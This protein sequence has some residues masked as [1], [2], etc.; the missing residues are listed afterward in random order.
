MRNGLIITAI[1]CTLLGHTNMAVAQQ[2][3]F[4]N[5]T[6]ND[7][8]ISN[9]I[10]RIFQDSKGFMWI[11]TW[12]GLSKYNGYNF[13]N[14]NTANGLSQNL[15][16][17][18][19]ENKNGQLYIALNSGDID[20]LDGNRVMGKAVACTAVV[21]R[22]ITSPTNQ[23]IA[24]T[25]REGILELS[26]GKMVKPAQSFPAQTY[27]DLIWLSDSLFI[28]SDEN[29]L[30]AF[31]RHFN[32][33]TQTLVG[34]N[35][36]HETKL[37]QD[38]K[39]RIWLGTYTGLKLMYGVPGKNR[40]TAFAP[41][42]AAFAIP[43]LQQGK[44]NAIFEDAAGTIWFGTTDGL[45][46]INTDGSNQLLTVKNGLSSNIVTCLMED[47]ENNLWVGT[48][49][50]ISK[51]VTKGGVR[52]YPIE[53]GVSSND[54]LFLL[55]PFKKDHFLVSTNKG[56]KIFNANTGQ[57]SATARDG[58]AW[59][60]VVPATAP[61]LFF[62]SGNLAAF[63]TLTSSFTSKQELPSLAVSKIAG[64]K[65]G[66][67]FLSDM[68]DLYFSSGNTLVKIL[69][70]RIS[71]LLVDQQGDLWAGTWQNGLF[72]IRYTFTRNN[73]IILAKQHL[74]PYQNTR[75]LFEDAQQNIWVGTR[76]HG[77]YRVAKNNGGTLAVAGFN[78]SDGLTS[79]FIKA[80]RQDARGNVWVAFYQGLD[81]L[82]AEGT[83][84]RVFNFSKVNNY[85]ASVIGMETDS[86]RS[87][88]LATGEGLAHIT[89]GNMEKFAPLPVYI[90][91]INTPDSTY[92]LNANNIQLGHLQ[93]QLLF[94]FSSP[95]FINERQ[96]LYS[97]RL[98]GS[99]S[100]E[101]SKQ[102]N[103][104]TVSYASLNPGHYIFEVRN[105]GWNGA[106]GKPATFTFTIRPPFWQTWWFITIAFF[107]GVLFIYQ[108]VK[109][110]EKNIKAI[111]AEKLK[112][113]QLNASQLKSKLEMEQIINY[114]SNS[115]I[116]KNT[117]DEVLW[118]V[119]RNLIGRLGF[120]DCMMYLW[121]ED[122]TRMI[123]KSGFGPKGSKEQ[124]NKQPFDVLPG[125]GVVGYVMQSKEP[126]LIPDTSLDSRYRPDEMVRLSE[127]TVPVIYNN[128]IIG[129][130]DSEHHERNFYT[131]QHLQILSTI[132][133]LMANKIKGIETEQLLQHTN[134]KMYS[135]NEQLLKARLEALRAQMNPHFIFNCL[136]SI[137]NLIQM[138]EKE[139]ATL[140]LSKFA[141]LIRSILENSASDT[142]PCWKDMETLKL[143]LE[144]EALRFDNKF[145]YRINV[146]DEILHGD[147]K[148]PP[149]IIQPFVENAIHH[150]LLNKIEGSKHLMISVSVA[151]NQISYVIADNGVGRAK[152]NAYKML[153]KPSHASMGMQITT[154]R[155][156]LFNRHKNGF[157]HIEDL[158]SSEGKPAGT[159]VS[160]Q[161]INQS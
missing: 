18:I 135:I 29:S 119:A 101:W 28:A 98:T 100:A 154:D 36:Y 155:I 121:N 10:R 23:V 34:D 70:Y 111:A 158:L 144:L 66:N 8:L 145:T 89:D 95:G 41:L 92:P 75:C 62:S 160:I 80:I 73:F 65:N 55:Y 112:V 27:A 37:Y 42:P 149:L 68:E 15:V 106:W 4:K 146:Q 138:D 45:V 24:L 114:F 51:I 48:A 152:A 7:G 88:W 79:N 90:T 99:A 148:V 118:D 77:V 126:L 19:Y 39:K 63:D 151:N 131:P 130:I 40:P 61:P 102:G 44:I 35:K 71:S 134:F 150:G 56:T 93:N 110:R 9:A 133:T 38:S 22:F 125:Q 115:L 140:Y 97:Y 52:L 53:N 6:A 59:R 21:N 17:D 67:L 11:A 105:L 3:L 117:I 141:K 94:E 153:N 124:I 137:D 54:N 13:K 83:S 123:Q 57:F 64:D 156:N 5:Y 87:I 91:S 161:L 69:N 147:Y 113:Q 85:Y 58:K 81:K 104:H 128:E 86:A 12:E 136:T 74:L 16:N 2:P 107:C 50:G 49:V 30:K 14:F 76:Y 139:K 122:K 127:I 96:L 33:L 82:I 120:V 132:A 142:V 47:K 108:F 20:M 159:K 31:D 1:I 43:E 32:L 46:K 60:G 84:F 26:Y 72:R 109:W 143:Y 78:Q 25:D 116:D 103:Q 157:V 129:V